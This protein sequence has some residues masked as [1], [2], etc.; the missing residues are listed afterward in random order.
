MD[1]ANLKGEIRKR[2]SRQADFAIAIGIHPTSLSAKLNGKTEWKS[3]EIVAAC[4][5]LGIPLQ[6]APEYFFGTKTEKTQLI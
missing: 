6:N 4:N 5:V 1:Y 3:D 2:F